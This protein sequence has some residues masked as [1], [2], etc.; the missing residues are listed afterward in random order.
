M[1]L[2][3]RRHDTS[4][5]LDDVTQTPSSTVRDD[6]AVQKLALGKRFGSQPALKD[7]DLEV[8]R[9]C[10]FGFLGPNGAGKTTL[11]RPWLGLAQPAAGRIRLLG[12]VLGSVS[13]A[14]R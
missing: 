8:P 11:I 6:L 9:G 10:A 2:A 3:L 5:R 14:A 1:T 13:G 12:P 7:V 4:T